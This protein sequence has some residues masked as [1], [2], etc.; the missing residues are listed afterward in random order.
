[1]FL[2]E[3]KSGQIFIVNIDSFVLRAAKPYLATIE[4]TVH[5]AAERP[6]KCRSKMEVQMCSN[7]LLLQLH[8]ISCTSVKMNNLNSQ[9]ISGKDDLYF[10]VGASVKHL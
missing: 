8:N 6:E 9:I 10:A 2:D 5:G 3:T 7:E 4:A 1:M